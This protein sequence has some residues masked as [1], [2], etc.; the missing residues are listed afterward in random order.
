MPL[1]ANLS[2]FSAER[3]RVESLSWLTRP[4]QLLDRSQLPIS[5]VSTLAQS[6]WSNSHHF[7]WRQ[8]IL[9]ILRTIGSRFRAMVHCFLQ[10]CDLMA[11]QHF[12]DCMGSP[13]KW[14]CLRQ[15]YGV[16]SK[17]LGNGLP[18]HM[19]TIGYTLL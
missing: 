6:E 10:E 16:L 13:L 11:L 1:Q 18:A 9:A 19:V 7:H 14:F 12:I 2:R 5:V 8:I 4:I 3:S 17:S 15:C